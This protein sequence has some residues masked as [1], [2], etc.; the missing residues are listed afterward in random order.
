MNILQSKALK[1]LTQKKPLTKHQNEQNGK[2]FE[3]LQCL[4][5]RRRR[6]SFI[7]LYLF[8]IFLNVRQTST[9]ALRRS[10]FGLLKEVK[11]YPMQ[12]LPDN[13]KILFNGSL[14]YLKDVGRR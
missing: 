6:F 5:K 4:R 10:H 14:Y 2:S 8:H 7:Y 1:R 11:K 13:H 12:T 9:S 3:A